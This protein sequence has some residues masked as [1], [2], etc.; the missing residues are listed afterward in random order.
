VIRLINRVKGSFP[1]K[2]V[3]EQIAIDGSVGHLAQPML[4]YSYR[5]RKEYWN[6]ADTYTSLTA[7]E[8]Q[9]A[10][11]SKTVGS[12]LLYTVV[13]P[14]LTFGSIFLRHKGFVDGLTGFEFALYSGLH[15]AIAYKKYL[16][17]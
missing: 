6:K 14:V 1:C 2:S 9:K 13:K 7:K 11:V 10:S 3:H 5:T 17:L 15:W 4:H 12:F 16:S 8:F